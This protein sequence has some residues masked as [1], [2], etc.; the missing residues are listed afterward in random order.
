MHPFTPWALLGGGAAAWLIGRARRPPAVRDAALCG[1]GL[2]TFLA[3]GL[4]GEN[5]LEGHQQRRLLAAPLAAGAAFAAS[6]ARRDGRPRAAGWLVGS[7]AWL[8]AAAV[9]PA[10]GY[11]GHAWGW[12]DPLLTPAAWA[13]AA[14]ATF[15]D[16]PH[17][18]RPA[19]DHDRRAGDE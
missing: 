12:A 10:A 9:V 19:A 8:V 15:V 13:C 1:T 16:R 5:L 14:A 4:W 2:L 18:D 7:T 6:K 17:P 3:L 11:R